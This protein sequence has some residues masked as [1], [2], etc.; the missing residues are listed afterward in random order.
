[1]I[2]QPRFGIYLE[3]VRQWV[4]VSVIQEK[5]EKSDSLPVD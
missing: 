1:M 2:F 4:G 5:I 3:F